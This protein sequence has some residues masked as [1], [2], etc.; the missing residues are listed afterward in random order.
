MSLTVINGTALVGADLEPLEGAV[1][2]IVDGT[3]MSV[4]SGG[5]TS[6]RG[7]TLDARGRYIVP[8]LIDWHVHLDLDPIA[9][10]ITSW[11]RPAA[12]RGRTIALN[13]LRSLQAGVTTVRDLGS[14]DHS[15]L[16]FRRSVVSNSARGVAPRILASGRMIVMTGGHANEV[17]RIADG[18]DQVREAAREQLHAGADVIKVMASGGFSTPGDP[19][20]AEYT[21]EELRAAV[22]EARRA[23]VAVAAHSHANAGILGALE[24]GVDTIEHGGL[25]QDD[26]VAALAAGSTSLVPT[27][28][29]MTAPI[30]DP[31]VQPEV[32]AAYG[33]ALPRY[34]HSIKSALD[35]GVSI[36]A[37]TDAG[38]YLNGF[39]GLVDELEQYVDLGASAHSAL[40]SATAAGDRVAGKPIGRI[41]AGWAGD[42]VLVD[43]NPD[44][45]ISALRAVHAVVADGTVVD[46]RWIDQ[47]L[48][49]YVPR[50]SRSLT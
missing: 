38:T 25:L 32:A 42:L 22:N 4:E 50:S 2:E 37:G 26:G 18:A 48:A 11:R 3:I 7:E 34:R 6:P 47:T 46:L 17:G 1:I 12:E 27:L 33:A 28:R 44:D 35:S 20:A 16:E 43:S 13:A 14:A 19:N 24:A 5:S 40:V 21:V 9:D 41:E 36:L 30:S 45:Q 23:G 15:V 10:P 31:R 8:G 39:G 49:R 29:A